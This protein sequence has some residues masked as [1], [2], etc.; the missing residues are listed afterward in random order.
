MEKDHIESIYQEKARNDSNSKDLANT[1]NIL[2]KTVYGDVNRFVFEL[3]QNADDSPNENGSELH[4]TFHLFENH[5]L[6]SH[7]GKHFDKSDVSG[8]SRVGSLDSQKDKH[9]N[10]T[11]YKGIGFKSVFRTSDCVQILSNGYKFKFDKHHALW[12]SDKSY[13][14]QVIPIW[15][16]SV[17]P[18]VLP[19]ID[20]SEVNTII[21]IDSKELIRAEILN[22]FKDCQII[23]F[24]RNI[25]SIQFKRN[26]EVQF[27]ITKKATGRNTY[28]LYYNDTLRSNWYIADFV[29]DISDSLRRNLSRLSD[30]ECPIKLKEAKN[31]KITIAA[32]I[33]QQGLVALEKTIIYNYLPTKVKYGFPYIVNADFITNAERTE[34]L[35]NE[36]NQFLFG[37]IA[38]SQVKL[39]A[40]LN[41]TEFRD[42]IFRI[43]KKSF[44]SSYD[45]LTRAFNNELSS[46]IS[47]IPFIPNISNSALLKVHECLVD[48]LHYTKHFPEQ[49]VT[50]LYNYQSKLISHTV[51][52]HDVL[53]SLGAAQFGESELPSL[54]NSNEFIKATKYERG[55]PFRLIEFLYKSKI[56][57]N[58]LKSARFIPDNNG[59][60]RSPEELYFPSSQSIHEITFTELV[61][62]HSDIVPN[63]DKRADL[64]QWLTNLGIRSPQDLEILRKS[65]MPMIERDEIS[66]DNTIAVTRFIFS[67]YTRGELADND[68]RS[69]KKLKVLTNHGMKGLPHTYLSDH[70]DPHLKL[71]YLVKDLNYIVQNYVT[72]STDINSWKAFF[73]RLHAKEKIT[74]VNCSRLERLEFSEKLPE[75]AQYVKWIDSVSVD[76]GLDKIKDK[77]KH[78]LS[79]VRYFF[80]LGLLKS[81]SYAKLFWNTVLADW[82]SYQLDEPRTCYHYNGN[83]K[84]IPDYLQYYVRNF[85]SIPTV[86]NV[87]MTSPEVYAP[88]FKDIACGKLPVADFN[89]T[90]LPKFQIKYIGLK[91][92]IEIDKC[93]SL[94]SSLI[95]ETVTKDI[96]RQIFRIYDEI[97]SSYK[98]GDRSTKD[99]SAISLLSLNNTYQPVKRL[100]HINAG[101]I[102]PPVSSDRFIQFPESFSA[103]DISLFC[104]L[105]NLRIIE[106][107]DLVFTHKDDGKDRSLL[108]KLIESLPFLA[109]VLSHRDSSDFE[110]IC[111][112]MAG[113]IN[114]MSVHRADML[115]L[116]YENP[117][118][119]IIFDSVISTYRKENNFFFTGSWQSPLQVYSIS[120]LLCEYL[121]IPD[122][123]KELSLFLQLSKAEIVLWMSDK[124]YDMP[125]MALTSDEN[126]HNE[127]HVQSTSPKEAAPLVETSSPVS[128]EFFTPEVEATAADIADVKVSSITTDPVNHSS[129]AEPYKKLSNDEVRLEIGMWSEEY[130]YRHLMAER[131]FSSVIWPNKDGEAYL[132]YDFEVIEN[133]VTKYIEVKGTPS[134]KKDEFYLSRN[135]WAFMFEKQSDYSIYRLYNAGKKDGLEIRII[136]DP[137]KLIQEGSIMPNSITIQL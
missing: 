38:L 11:G 12:A 129:A 15:E 98:E 111:H 81:A 94:L 135:E 10:K 48:S 115:T 113:A 107:S 14:W 127:E 92:Y 40:Q 117:D 109:T 136:N 128:I 132:P 43:F 41:E 79:N 67:I 57:S 46:A 124:G 18:E 60:L 130:I 96:K 23:L 19:H 20:F 37:I 5:L 102:S 3:L 9:L 71:E 110:T 80:F 120:A 39:V 1:L 21:K 4:V 27:V 123:E 69:L 114:S 47:A 7:N 131:R 25:K 31:T 118:G 26:S 90:W 53:V 103:G 65:I 58:I 61:F 64:R 29:N 133:G 73:V 121:D 76:P 86:D 84:P 2:S 101:S 77:G 106:Y 116:Q 8:I 85:P 75:F 125:V 108:E 70:Y 137:F 68:Y 87:S 119:E 91:E 16:D 112:K 89:N 36:W 93:L 82:N 35:K 78:E 24:Q 34:L 59:N 104:K 44:P 17:H 52:R 54:F 45:N 63:L 74:V 13:P 22:V 99:P 55:F 134:S 42:Q 72:N 62:V 105:F 97:V 49:H 30:E 50:T 100:H 51:E 33:A 66:K 95:C 56:S 83:S 6:F 32:R 88:K 126:V 28:S 122:M